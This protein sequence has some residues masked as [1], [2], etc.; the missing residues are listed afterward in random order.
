MHFLDVLFRI[1]ERYQCN[2]GSIRQN[3]FF[4]QSWDGPNSDEP[5]LS[6]CN[7]NAEKI[8]CWTHRSVESTL[9]HSVLL[10]I[11]G[12]TV[13]FAL[14]ELVYN[15][16]Y[17]SRKPARKLTRKVST[18]I[19][20]LFNRNSSLSRKKSERAVAENYVQEE[21]RASNYNLTRGVIDNY[22]CWKS[23]VMFLRK[24]HC[25][26]LFRIDEKFLCLCSCII[27][28]SGYL[29]M[30]TKQESGAKISPDLI[31]DCIF[32]QTIK[33]VRTFWSS[34]KFGSPFL[35]ATYLLPH[36]NFTLV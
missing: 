11:A 9:M 32:P 14:C 26:S 30:L 3:T 34:S 31:L 8:T 7:N 35:T 27:Y 21:I 36:C 12:L 16:W 22:E 18:K 10:I 13:F 5:Y 15:V 24:V 33:E 2:L 1:P 25:G 28:I 20:V 29:S 17:L 4:N 23:E 6:P 19:D